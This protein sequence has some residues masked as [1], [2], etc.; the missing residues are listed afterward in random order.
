MDH[1]FFHYNINNKYFKIKIPSLYDEEYIKKCIDNNSYQ[2]SDN[3]LIIT[4][5]ENIFLFDATFDELRQQITNLQDEVIKLKRNYVSDWRKVNNTARQLLIFD[6]NLNTI[7]TIFT[8]QFTVNIAD[9]KV[10]DITWCQNYCNAHSEYNSALHSGSV[11][12]TTT[13]MQIPIW[14]GGVIGRFW[15]SQKWNTWKEGYIRVIVKP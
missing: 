12:F 10:Y 6:H 13:Q 2:I 11:C 1:K 8:I 15:D 5:T 7:P 14:E 4:G 9:D 3:K